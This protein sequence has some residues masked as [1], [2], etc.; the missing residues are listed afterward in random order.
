MSSHYSAYDMVLG[1]RG[2]LN[3][4]RSAGR[5]GRSR[6][7]KSLLKEF[8]VSP[9]LTPYAIRTIGRSVAFVALANMRPE[10]LLGFIIVVQFCGTEMVE[11]PYM[12]DIC[13][14]RLK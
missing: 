13:I 14:L 2:E 5:E 12:S 4:P 10:N 9:Q 6:G 3:K 1:Q 8:N 7:A 11:E